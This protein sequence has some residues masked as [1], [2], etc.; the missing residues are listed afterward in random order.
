MAWLPRVARGPKRPL[1]A[2]GRGPSAR[3]PRAPSKRGLP[4]EGRR[5]P[6]G[7]RAN[8][9]GAAAEGAQALQG[10][11][12]ADRPARH[13]NWSPL[14][15]GARGS[16]TYGPSGPERPRAAQGRERTSVE[17]RS[18]ALQF[19]AGC[20]ARRRVFAR[21]SAIA[22][23]VGQQQHQ[24]GEQARGLVIVEVAL[25]ADQFLVEAVAVGDVRGGVQGHRRSPHWIAR[26]R[27]NA[28]SAL[29]RSKARQR[30][31]TC[32]SGRIRYTVPGWP[33]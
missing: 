23:V 15:E 30:A 14:S 24:L 21:A 13:S 27:R 12:P 32:W 7:R 2:Q 4:H 11:G 26:Q 19:E 6:D 22:D 20:A 8:R 5:R 10:G 16:G 17:G 28:A 3:L 1:A 33:S 29:A 9:D 25:R 31:A 18:K